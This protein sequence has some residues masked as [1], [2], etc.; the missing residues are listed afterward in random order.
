MSSVEV[1]QKVIPDVNN[2]D[3]HELNPSDIYVNVND[4]KTVNTHDRQDYDEEALKIS[5]QPKKKKRYRHYARRIFVGKEE[6]EEFYEHQH[7]KKLNRFKNEARRH[8]AEYFGTFFLIYFVCGIQVNQGLFPEG[9]VANIDKGLVSG[10]IL[11]GLIFAFGRVSG[12]HFNPVVTLAFL[13][14]GSFKFWRFITY[15]SFQFGGAVTGAAVL[16]GLFGNIDHLGTTTPGTGISN[17]E[18]FGVEIILTFLLVT[19][20]LSTAENA[21]ILGVNAGIAVGAAFGATQ[22]W[23]WNITGASVNPW[24]TIGPTMISNFGWRTYWIYIIGPI[25]GSTVAV[26]LQ[27]FTVSG[28]PRAH[29]KSASKGSGKNDNRKD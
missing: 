12:A 27:R 18:A 14:R 23:G 25:I 2:A 17:T 4:T 8:V 5:S 9:G 26:I 15:I 13:L 29:T 16:Y 20:V 1:I 7:H 22:I 24:R 11:I 28:V 19:V 10:F 21:K 3:L 6:K